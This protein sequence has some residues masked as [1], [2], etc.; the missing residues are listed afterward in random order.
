MFLFVLL[1]CY[2]KRYIFIG[3]EEEVKGNRRS[4]SYYVVKKKRYINY[5]DLKSN[6]K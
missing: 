5:I 2:L 4:W 1:V 6:I 3:W